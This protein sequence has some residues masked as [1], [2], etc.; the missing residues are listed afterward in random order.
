MQAQVHAHLQLPSTLVTIPSAP[1]LSNNTTWHMTTFCMG[2]RLWQEHEFAWGNQFSMPKG[3]AQLPYHNSNNNNP[4]LI[5]R[6]LFVSLTLS[7]S[8]SIYLF[9]ATSFSLSLCG[10][11]G[12]LT[13]SGDRAEFPSAV[14]LSMVLLIRII[15]HISLIELNAPCNY[16]SVCVCVC[17]KYLQ[18]AAW[19]FHILQNKLKM[20]KRSHNTHKWN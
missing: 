13:L 14:N 2:P 20:R 10:L 8:F 4:C 12:S 18:Y 6:T 1:Y 17:V 9:L 7:L 11:L 3:L 5:W 15:F 16:S 19:S